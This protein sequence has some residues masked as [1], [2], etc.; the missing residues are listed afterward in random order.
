IND[1]MG[2]SFGDLLLKDI[3]EKIMNSIRS[4]DT[5]SRQGGDEFTVLLDQLASIEEAKR[6]IEEIQMRI[7]DAF[8]INEIE[9]HVAASIGVALYP[10]HGD[11][12]DN[13]IKYSDIALF[14]AKELG[15]NQYAIYTADMNQVFIRRMALD[16]ELR[17]AIRNEELSLYYQPQINVASGEIIGIE[18]L[19][20]WNSLI[21]GDVPPS[22]MIPVA[23]E[24]GHIV[25]I[26]E[27]VLTTACRQLKTWLDRGYSIPKVA[28]N[29]SPVQFNDDKLVASVQHILHTTGL[30][31]Q[32]LELEITEGTAMFNERAVINKI[33][34][35]KD[36]GINVALDDFGT[37][38]SCLAYL[39][40]FP[41]DTLKIDRSF[42]RNITNN[43]DN[44]VLVE[45][46]I[47][48]AHNFSINVIAEGVDTFEQF[49]MLRE[50]KCDEI[51]GYLISE[52]LHS[53]QLIHLINK[54][55]YK[56]DSIRAIS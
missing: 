28:V 51:Q 1:T 52:P 49:Q 26:G 8:V 53:E 37:G 42:I 13:L 41:V 9:V 30:N 54:Y 10:R 33:H 27:W 15:K 45:T 16:K 44:E 4:T 46:I 50:K 35:L 36:L 25:Q 3:G 38:Y 48:M 18:A 17:S 23:E 6:W 31:P 11:D 5:V 47:G 2:H 32:C 19:V 43:R 14:K 29:I 21:L 39:S 40:Q 22:E 7:Q 55:R 20:R 56:P 12:S 24:N 34:A